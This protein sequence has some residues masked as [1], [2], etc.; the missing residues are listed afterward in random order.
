MK[1]HALK[2]LSSLDDMLELGYGKTELVEDIIGLLDQLS[3]NHLPREVKMFVKHCDIT[4]HEYSQRT[5]IGASDSLLGFN[6]KHFDSMNIYNYYT[7]EWE[8]WIACQQKTE[9]EPEPAAATYTSLDD[10]EDGCDDESI[11]VSLHRHVKSRLQKEFQK[12][13]KDWE[14]CNDYDSDSFDA[15]EQH[16][17]RRPP[18]FIS[19]PN[20]T[21]FRV[22]SHNDSKKILDTSRSDLEHILLLQGKFCS[23]GIRRM[24]KVFTHDK[25]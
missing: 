3:M 15:S 20:G 23:Q 9:P 12:A 22:L 25:K 18:K 1:I 13:V 5:L 16:E 8:D 10:E 17:S 24:S 2:S 4:T 7:P 14:D 19:C 21:L 6:V 11:S